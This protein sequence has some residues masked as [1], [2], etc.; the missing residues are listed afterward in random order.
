MLMN[1]ELNSKQIQDSQI[2]SID[3]TILDLQEKTSTDILNTIYKKEWVLSKV[4]WILNWY[5]IDPSSLT[6]QLNA[7]R[8]EFYKLS[9]NDDENFEHDLDSAA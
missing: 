4:I 7:W 8:E 2:T 9:A 5:K 3:E 1:N 6:E